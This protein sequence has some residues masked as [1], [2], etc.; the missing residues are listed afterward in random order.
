MLRSAV[1]SCALILRDV[2]PLVDVVFHVIVPYRLVSA[3]LLL[4]TLVNHCR[5]I[6]PSGLSTTFPSYTNP[7][8]FFPIFLGGG[9][10]T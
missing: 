2:Y 4:V 8:T 1:P 3:T 6:L 10:T 5:K 7:T 9:I